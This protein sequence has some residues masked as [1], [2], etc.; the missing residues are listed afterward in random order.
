MRSPLQRLVPP[1]AAR[2]A[3][4]YR[5]SIVLQI[6]LQELVR[7][8]GK[9]DGLSAVDVGV[10]NPVMSLLLRRL[11]GT[12]QTVTLTDES[13][14][15]AKLALKESVHRLSEG[16][17]PF[18]N[19]SVDLVVVAGVLERVQDDAAF[20][21]ECHRILKPTG[22]LVVET[23]H[24]K[25]GSF[26]LWLERFLGR[27][28]ESLGLPRDGYNESDIFQ[29][30][31]HG[32]DVVQ[33]RSYLRFFT[34]L[35]Q[36]LAVAF[37]ER[38]VRQGRVDRSIRRT[39]FLGRLTAWFAFQIDYLIWFARGFRLIASAKRRAWLP[40]KTPVLTDGRSISE[41]VLTRAPK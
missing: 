22:R 11:G 27:D 19:K 3:D 31:K 41:A 13:E 29:L 38:S 20:I 28:S 8:I 30:L 1:E 10:E 40:R 32:F 36:L 5:R 12:W 17:I 4:E 34:R 6:Q 26:I 15:A 16:H 14:A 24:R 37:Y 25:P 35:N 23:T 9:T 39:R 7:T 33:V 2:W 21:E 18:Q